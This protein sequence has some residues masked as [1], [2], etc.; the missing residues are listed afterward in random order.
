MIPTEPIKI[1]RKILLIFLLLL[2]C[3]GDKEPVSPQ[4]CG[5]ILASVNKDKLDEMAKSIQSDLQLLSIKS[6]DVSP[7]GASNSWLYI[8]FSFPSFAN[9][10]FHTT[11]TDA[12]WDSS[13]ESTA[14]G[15]S[16]IS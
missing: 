16:F 9:Y 6:M 13:S 7:E 12:V 8:Y 3:S 10:Y 2:G 14:I 5:D 1:M 15:V 4:K 11:C